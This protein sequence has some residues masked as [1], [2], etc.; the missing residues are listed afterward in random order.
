MTASL[1]L[2]RESH[3]PVTKSLITT[4]NNKESA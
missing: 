1:S 3:L 4:F 2:C